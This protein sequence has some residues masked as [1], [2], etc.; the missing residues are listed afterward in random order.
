MSICL[1]ILEIMLKALVYRNF[2]LHQ[3]W[4]GSG[5]T[6]G[7]ACS[8]IAA[9]GIIVFIDSLNSALRETEKYSKIHDMII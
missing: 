6:E 7:F 1:R 9:R 8:S 2:F 5:P 3:E 4:H